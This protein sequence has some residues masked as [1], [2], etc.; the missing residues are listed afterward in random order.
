[1][2][3]APP[4]LAI[5]FIG[6]LLTIALLPMLSAKLWH[7]HYGKCVALWMLAFIIPDALLRGPG[8]M[9][10][11]VAET[12]LLEYLPFILLLG[13]FYVIAGGLRVTGTPHGAP[14]VNTAMLAIGTLL[15]CLIGTTGAAM[16]M[17]R[18]VL[19]ANRHRRHIVHI[20]V[21][22]ILLAA[23]VGGALTPLGNPPVFLG[24][25]RGVPFLWPATHLWA[26]TLLVVLGLLVTFYAL[27]SYIFHR[28]HRVDPEVLPE[29]EK[30]GLEGAVN[31]ALIAL[32]IF[33]VM[34]RAIWR[35]EA[36]LDLFG[37]RWGVVPIMSDGLLLLAALLSLLLSPRRTRE[38][39]E[40]EWAP[41]IEVAI[42]FAGIFI[43]IL[44]VMAIVAAG[45][46][47]GAA[48]LFARLMVAGVPD[49]RLF[50]WTAGLLSAVLDNAPTYLVFFGFAGGDAARLTGDL[51]RTL[52]A[53]SS[54]ASFFGALTYIGNAP[55]LLIKGMAERQ[56][57]AMPGF[58]GYVGWA[59]L[60]LLPWLLLVQIIFFA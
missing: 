21:F 31:I 20:V 9:L 55:N 44:P 56:G 42:L 53:I 28:A 45:P 19:R 11:A 4:L 36:S 26:P 30:L 39:N 10:Q 16:M 50:F 14:A 15:A 35:S 57:V 52:A 22:L 3:A 27:D 38:R 1:M 25:L 49:D 33:A 7:R 18:P 51:A 6:L 24:Y 32:A 60:C 12:A 58:F 34:L 17:V 2:S 41:M 37:L 59:V 23:N 43:T 8:A 48:P 46:A 29:I 5:P 13:A 47:G 54:A 40:F